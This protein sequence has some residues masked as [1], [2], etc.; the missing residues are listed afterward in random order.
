MRV[1]LTCF[2]LEPWMTR[3]LADLRGALGSLG[4]RYQPASS[5]AAAD[6]VLYVAPGYNRFRGWTSRVFEEDSIARYPNRCFVFDFSDRPVTFLPG[7]YTSLPRRLVDPRRIRSADRWTR[8]AESRERQIVR[9]TPVDPRLLFSFRGYESAKVRRE[10]FA[11]KFSREDIATTRTYRW[12]DYSN[13]EQ[14]RLSY[15][16]EIRESAFVL[17]PRGLAPST[18]RLYETMQLG[19]VP[20]ILAD[21]WPAPSGPPWQDFSIRVS[22]HRVA[23]L[24]EILEPLRVDAVEMGRAARAAWESWMEPGPVL[25]RRWLQ[26]IEEILLTRPHEWDEADLRN[27]W[28]SNAFRWQNGIHPVQG[29]LHAARTKSLRSRVKTWFGGPD[30]QWTVLPP[31]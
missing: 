13:D 31:S 3:F 14:A 5:P 21:D 6:V 4:A 20:V 7:L 16:R 19:R 25:L 2:D 11:T 8:I 24:P 23:E 27:K 26:G 18:Y 15:L 29:L 17:C 9:S 28:T 12:Y 30:P 22:E 10:I 1:F